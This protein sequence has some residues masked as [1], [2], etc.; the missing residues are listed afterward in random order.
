MKNIM[1]QILQSQ[2]IV[3]RFNTPVHIAHKDSNVFTLIAVD[4]RE[5]VFQ[6]VKQSKDVLE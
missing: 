4:V 6:H 2:K 5:P 1:M 3:P